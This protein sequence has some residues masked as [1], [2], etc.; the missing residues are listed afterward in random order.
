VT[1]P[2]IDLVGAQEIAGRLGVTIH[3][4]HKWRQR[5]LLPAPSWRLGAGDIWQWETIEAWAR[6]T[7]RLA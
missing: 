2:T 1:T 6:E 5:N 3:T 4:V 7:G